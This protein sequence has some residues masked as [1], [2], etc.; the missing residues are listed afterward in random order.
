MPVRRDQRCCLLVY[1][2]LCPVLPYTLPG[3]SV[4]G[5]PDA[6]RRAQ[7]WETRK[8]GPGCFRGLAGGPC[9]LLGRWEA[10]PGGLWQCPVVR[11]FT[12]IATVLLQCF[13]VYCPC[14]GRPG[15]LEA[16]AVVSWGPAAVLRCEGGSQVSQNAEAQPPPRACP[17]SVLQPGSG[18]DLA[19]L[20]PAGLAR[21][22]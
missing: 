21:E 5:S 19:P 10:A 12:F 20:F 14:G 3:T 1:K 4:W 9:S 8:A 15:S 16:T 11:H 17:G 13:S 18:L 7:S 22:W 2:V 6:L